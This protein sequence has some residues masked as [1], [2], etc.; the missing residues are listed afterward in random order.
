MTIRIFFSTVLFFL[1]L[2]PVACGDKDSTPDPPVVK[3][4]E[5]EEPDPGVPTGDT[6]DW[7]Y[8]KNK[9][10]GKEEKFFAI[11]IW[12]IPGYALY[13]GAANEASAAIFRAK[14]AN[15]NIVQYGNIDQKYLKPYM[16]EKTFMASTF[17]YVLQYDYLNKK[18]LPTGADRDY[19]R[20]QF[21]KA[22]PNAPD[23]VQAFDN[24]VNSITNQ[25]QGYDLT[26]SSIDEIAL[27]GIARWFIPASVGDRIYESIKKRKSDAIVFVDLL[28][29]GRGSTFF[30]EKNYLKTHSAMPNNPPYDLLSE[31]ARKQ[32][33]FPLLG[34]FEAHDGTPVYKFDE[35]GE[36]SYNDP[37]A[38]KLRNIWFENVKQVAAAYKT[39][40][41]VFA[42]NAFSNFYADPTLAGITVD[43][44]KE[45]LGDKP[46][47]L[48]FDGNGYA[49]PANM[50]A[51]N[52]ADIVK[53][54]IYTSL[55]HGATGVFFWNDSSK[56]P[57]VFDAMQPVLKELNENL[58]ILYLPTIERKTAG[59]LHFMIKKEAGSGKKYIIAVNSSKTTTLQLN[60][61][62]L[63]KSSLSPMEVYI[64]PTL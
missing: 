58:P 54:Q 53:S 12:A 44:L 18:G 51:G 36:Y 38:T 39:N 61:Q 33:K 42:I 15:C 16:K 6:E 63:Q 2:T 40:G 14:T 4:E 62:G 64:S 27:G 19:Y 52:Y 13:E 45:G 47:W 28:G 26:F 10:T 11:G 30:F 57:I 21:M 50:S 31:E 24:A 8:R 32:T 56:E 9:E 22:N 60:I 5:P 34:F 48:Y 35:N 46:V 23:L 55:V 7:I 59:D 1:C 49:K 37:D 43:A 20:T 25:F 17:A 3:P 41:N 29:H